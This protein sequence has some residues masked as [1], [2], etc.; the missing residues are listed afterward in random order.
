M[1][2]ADTLHGK[3][4]WGCISLQF[5]DKA[6]YLDGMTMTADWI[7]NPHLKLWHE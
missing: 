6:H 3:W 2:L 5:H 7:N 4:D 1:Q